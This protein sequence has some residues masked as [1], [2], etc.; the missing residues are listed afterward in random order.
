[1]LWDLLF[2]LTQ[3]DSNNKPQNEEKKRLLFAPLICIPVERGRGGGGK[4]AFL[5]P[6]ANLSL[7]E[8]RM[9]MTLP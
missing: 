3:L 7:P 5:I 6:A 9:F 4:Y 8:A 1:M 2:D